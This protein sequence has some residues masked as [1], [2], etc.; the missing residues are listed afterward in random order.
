VCLASCTARSTRCISTDTGPCDH[1]LSPAVAPLRRW[2]KF[3]TPGSDS[4]P[5]R[6]NLIV[7]FTYCRGCQSCFA[8]SKTPRLRNTIRHSPHFGGDVRFEWLVLSFPP[9][10]PSDQPAALSECPAPARLCGSLPPGVPAAHPSGPFPRGRGGDLCTPPCSL[11]VGC[12]TKKT[13]RKIDIPARDT[14]R[15]KM[16]D[17]IL[18]PFGVGFLRVLMGS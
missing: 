1:N 16:V 15:D 18:S 14:I 6:L 17:E 10:A 7:F 11:H 2:T 9:P 4:T 13:K 12:P 5:A 3:R 8:M